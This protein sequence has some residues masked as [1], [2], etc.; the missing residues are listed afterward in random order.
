[1]KS[2]C[3]VVAGGNGSRMNSTIP[4]QF[5]QIGGVPILMHTLQQIH[6][7]D[8]TIELI[9]VLPAS[10]ITQWKDLCQ[11]HECLIPHKIVEGG[12]TRFD[13][14]KNGLKHTKGFELI[15]IHD[16]VRPLV[17]H[18][19]LSNC[20]EKAATSGTAIPVL[21]VHESVR[22][23]SLNHSIPVNRSEY[24][25]VQTPQVFKANILNDAYNQPW[26]A[27]FT[28]DASVVEQVGVA[29]HLVLGN[30]ENIKITF[31]EDLIIAKAFLKLDLSIEG[32]L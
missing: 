8:P 28:D 4:K 11:N 26:K 25:L 19:T 12:E 32:Q 13:S 23:G 30:R 10:E 7:F 6:K 3:I 20:F 17:S 22:K 5:I 24:F 14:V 1:M 27:E 2:C 21:P 15:A 31:P 29:V 16:G 18:Q 9:L